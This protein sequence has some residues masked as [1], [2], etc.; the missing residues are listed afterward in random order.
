M[1]TGLRVKE[2]SSTAYTEL[3]VYIDQLT[4]LLMVVVNLLT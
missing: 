2:L 4:S 3:Q 1:Y